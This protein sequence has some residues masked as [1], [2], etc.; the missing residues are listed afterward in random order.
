MIRVSPETG[1]S[2]TGSSSAPPRRPT[3]PGRFALAVLLLA[4]GPA[5]D[6]LAAQ[7]APIRPGVAWTS[8]SF[9]ASGQGTTRSAFLHNLDLTL[10]VDGGAF[11]WSGG[12]AF[13]YVLG[14][15]G[16]P[17]SGS[18]GDLQGISNI[19]APRALRL[20]EAWIE[21]GLAGG[22]AALLAGLFD[23]NGEFY[24]MER[25]D[26]F[27]HPSHGIGPEMA[28]SGQAGPSIFPVTSLAARLR[29]HVGDVVTVRGAVLD[30][31]PGDPDDPAATAVT[32][33]RDEGAL[34]VGELE[35]HTPVRVALGAWRYTRDAAPTWTAGSAPRRSRSGGYA[36]A[37]TDVLRWDD[38]GTL[39]VFVR[40]GVAAPEAH[41]VTLGW[42]GGVSVSGL[43]PARPDDRLGVALAAATLGSPYRR[44]LGAS[45]AGPTASETAVEFVYEVSFGPRMTLS[46]DAQMIRNPGADASAATVHAFGQRVSFAF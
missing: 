23:L 37:E 17:L 39:G 25:G 15:T 33:D 26:L 43:I 35:L 5:V 18:V 21:Q 11:G 36:V 41:E 19:E 34:L 9:R 1:R 16:D 3:L 20:Y 10:E 6:R 40:V 46:L 12:R 24:V 4:S 32:L 14:N 27:L 31:V 2:R 8:E 44:A 45:G 42:G 13:L 28:L 29:V 22:R 38:T 7:D 30:A